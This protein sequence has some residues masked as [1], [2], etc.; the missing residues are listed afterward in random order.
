MWVLSAHWGQNLGSDESLRAAGF[1]SSKH[2]V[3]F[4]TADFQ[5]ILPQHAAGES[6]SHRK[7]SEVIFENVS[8]WA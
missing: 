7:V 1:V 8:V 3:N 6:T 2:F 4:S 5:Q